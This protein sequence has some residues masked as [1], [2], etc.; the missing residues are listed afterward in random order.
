MKRFW[1]WL[2]LLFLLILAGLGIGINQKYFRVSRELRISDILAFASVSIALLALALNIDTSKKNINN[3]ARQ[4]K[5]NESERIRKQ[6]DQIAGWFEG[7]DEPQGEMNV[8]DN[9]GLIGMVTLQNA[10][11]VPVYDVFILSSNSGASDDFDESQFLMEYTQHFNVLK[12]GATRIRLET[13]GSA[14]GGVLPS[15]ALVFKDT[16]LQYWF[17]GPHGNLSLVDEEQ[18]HEIF[19]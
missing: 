2:L 9:G 19:R 12:P 1:L 10:S 13:A 3:M 16:S 15:V 11:A 14:I 17:R 18:V 8:G 7:F 4:L 6:A 5:V